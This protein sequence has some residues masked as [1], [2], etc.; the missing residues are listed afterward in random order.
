MVRRSFHSRALL[1][2]KFERG[3]CLLRFWDRNFHCFLRAD[4]IVGNVQ[5]FNQQVEMIAQP[6]D[7]AEK[8][9]VRLK[10]GCKPASGLPVFQSVGRNV[11]A[12]Q[13]VSEAL[14]IN[15]LNAVS[16]SKKF[17]RNGIGQLNAKA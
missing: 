11:L 7:R 15:D 6:L 10:L 14:P 4:L 8:Y 9:G 13:V 17:H 16:L 3:K 5:Q 12:N 2:V 1:I